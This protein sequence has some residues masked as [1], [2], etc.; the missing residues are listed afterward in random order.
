VRVLFLGIKILPDSIIYPL[1]FMFGV[2]FGSFANVLILR[3]PQGKSI[4]PSSRCPNCS[5]AIRWCD[6]IPIVSWFFLWGRCRS[7]R[8]PISFRYPLIEFLTGCLFC[9]VYFN[10]GFSYFSLE[11]LIFSYCAFVASVIDIEH[12]ILPDVFTLSGC[13]VG[14]LGAWLNPEREFL[15]ALWGFLLGGGI[16]YFVAYFGYLMYKREVMG[17]GDIKL[18]AWIGAVLG[19]KSILPVLIIAGLLPVP[20]MLVALIFKYKRLR[21]PIPFGPFIVA[22]VFI[23]VGLDAP[24]IVQWILPTNH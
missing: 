1:V 13:V 22:A 3:I 10:F 12:M 21:D 7:C 24:T 17:G 9:F 14:L 8:N 6:N 5:V 23:Y 2:V 16:L 11:F 18:L 4:V 19:L 20:L 15:D